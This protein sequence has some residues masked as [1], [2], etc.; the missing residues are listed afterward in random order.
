M[1]SA[2]ETFLRKA[3]YA[4]ALAGGGVLAAIVA[5]NVWTVVGGFIGLPFAGD[6][7]LTEMG[8]AIAAFMFLPYCQLADQ[9]VTADIFTSKLSAAVQ[10]RFSAIGS[11]LALGFAALLLWRM[12]FGMLDQKSYSLATTILQIPVWWA[13]LPA[14]ASLALLFIAAALSLRD[15]WTGRA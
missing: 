6:F 2:T 15:N 13:Y 14:L 11:V 12:Y 3:I 8:V 7:E 1:H 10:R 4:W 9:N 5:V